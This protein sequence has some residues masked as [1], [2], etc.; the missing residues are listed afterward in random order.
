[1]AISPAA[2][3]RKRRRLVRCSTRDVFMMLVFHL[4]SVTVHRF[5]R[6]LSELNYSEPSILILTGLLGLSRLSALSRKK[7]HKIGKQNLCEYQKSSADHACELILIHGAGVCMF[8]HHE[9]AGKNN[10]L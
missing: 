10:M 3:P 9:T 2:L 5:S 8:P 1:M 7:F 4:T 6:N